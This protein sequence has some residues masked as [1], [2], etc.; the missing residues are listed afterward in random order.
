[1]VVLCRELLT[2]NIS[3][4]FPVAAFISLDEAFGVKAI[5]GRPIQLLD[6]VIECLRDAV[7]VCL[8]SSYHVLLALA[9]RLITRFKETYPNDDY[10]EATAL[11]F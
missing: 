6:E 10:E 9:H 11:L 7:K 1:M 3:A 4:D 2:S 5:L 8:P